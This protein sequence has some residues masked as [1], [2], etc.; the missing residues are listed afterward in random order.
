MQTFLSTVFFIG[1]IFNAGMALFN[2]ANQ[3]PNDLVMINMLSMLCFG[4][5]LLFVER[6]K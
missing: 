1:V 6:E 3:S 2:V 4:V 5:A